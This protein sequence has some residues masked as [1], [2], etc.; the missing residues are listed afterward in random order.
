MRQEQG[1]LFAT[2][3]KMYPHSKE[4]IKLTRQPN[5]QEEVNLSYTCNKVI[6]YIV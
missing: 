1:M 3:G 6:L 5:E 4:N 2:N